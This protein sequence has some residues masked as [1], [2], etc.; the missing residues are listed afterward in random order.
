MHH[1]AFSPYYP[2]LV[3]ISWY[4]SVSINASPTQ[5]PPLVSNASLAH[6]HLNSPLLVVVQVTVAN[7]LAALLVLHEPVMHHTLRDSEA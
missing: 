6:N 2:P 4:S 5:Y 3:I 1:Y 7:A